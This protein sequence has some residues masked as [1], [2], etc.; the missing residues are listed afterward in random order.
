MPA[1]VNNTQTPLPKPSLFCYDNVVGGSQEVSSS[2]NSFTVAPSMSTG[3]FFCVSMIILSPF[4]MSFY[5]VNYSAFEGVLSSGTSTSS[6]L[7]PGPTGGCGADLATQRAGL[8]FLFSKFYGTPLSTLN[9]SL[10]PLIC[11]TTSMCNSNASKSFL[12]NR[13]RHT[14]SAVTLHCIFCRPRH[15]KGLA[16]HVD[17]AHH[18]T[19]HTLAGPINGACQWVFSYFMLLL[20]KACFCDLDMWDAQHSEAHTES[21]HSCLSSAGSSQQTPVGAIIGG[22]VGGCLMLALVMGA[23]WYLRRRGA[24]GGSQKESQQQPDTF[25]S[26]ASFAPSKG[27]SAPEAAPQDSGLAN[28]YEA[29]LMVRFLLK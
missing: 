13:H 17:P 19:A 21:S 20:R 14:D 18:I 23:W 24:T 5:N 26:N 25:I 9:T 29:F 4:D 11:C 22:V 28:A 1:N 10:G 3:N 2:N 7:P 16:N 8:L 12:A 27:V 6:A 15:T